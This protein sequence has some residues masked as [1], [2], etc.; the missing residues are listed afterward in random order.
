MNSTMQTIK[1]AIRLAALSLLALGL[2]ATPAWAGDPVALWTAN[3]VAVGSAANGQHDAQ[4]I[5]DG[6]GGTIIVWYDY[7]SGVDNPDIYAQRL[8]SNGTPLWTAGGVPVCTAGGVQWLPRITGDGAGGVII[9]WEDRRGG[10]YPHIYAQRLDSNGTPLWTANGVPVCTANQKQYNPEITSDGAGGAIIT[11]QDYRVWPYDQTDVYA[12]RLNGSGTPQWAA[13]GVVVSAASNF[14]VQPMIIS[15]GA[16]GAIVVWEDWRNGAAQRDIYAQR[17]NSSG[18]PQWTAN[19]VGVCT[20]SGDLDNLKITADGAG[21]V[22]VT[23]EDFR[24]SFIRDIYAQRLNGSGTPQ[25]TANGVAVCVAGDEQF[26]PKIVGD[27]VG[28]AFITWWDYRNGVDHDIYAQRLNSG[29]TPQWTANGVAVCTAGQ[30]QYE[31]QPI[32]DGIGGVIIAWQDHRNGLD[33]DVYLQRLNSSGIPQWTANG[34]AICTAG[35]T[36]GWP[37]LV[38]D[39]AGPNSIVIVWQDGRNGDDNYDIYAQRV[40]EDTTPPGNPTSAM[41]THGVSNGAWQKAVSDPAFTWSGATDDLSGVKG[42]RWYFGDSPAGTPITW[43]VSAAADPGNVA[44][45]TYYLRLSTEDNANNVSSPVTLFTFRYDGN[46]PYF[47]SISVTPTLSNGV[48]QA[49][50]PALTFSW[51]AGDD[52]SGVAHVTEVSVSGTLTFSAVASH[53]VSYGGSVSDT[54]TYTVTDHAGWGMPALWSGG[55]SGFSFCYVDPSNPGAGTPTTPT[56]PTTWHSTSPTLTVSGG[57][58]VFGAPYLDHYDYQVWYRG[59]LSDTFQ[60]IDSGTIPPDGNFVPDWAEPGTYRLRV[61]AVSRLDDGTEIA[62]EWTEREY[63]VSGPG[64]YLPI[65]LKGES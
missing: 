48:C 34:V 2:F 3:G 61:R 59:P 41:E 6:A 16:G 60:L 27:G 13:N 63:V 57:G 55:S 4:I 1:R 23:W 8:D 35:G 26:G 15:D 29:G 10:T 62:S 14:Q 42:Y 18:T 24:N 37:R 45:G 21:G 49:S 20:H 17:L 11:W 19:G 12:Q 40:A 30:G 46:P 33:D 64:I 50:Y 39:G 25:W 47:N 56:V 28:G 58:E 53:T 31:P 5:S 52:H 65:I 22:M 44:S 54:L 38:K 43:T 51:E 36:Q 7:R 9:V 32:S